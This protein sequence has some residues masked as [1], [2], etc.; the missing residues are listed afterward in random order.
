MTQFIKHNSSVQLFSDNQALK[1]LME[2]KLSKSKAIEED[3]GEGRDSS[4]TV[5]VYKYIYIFIFSFQEEDN[6]IFSAYLLII[7][8]NTMV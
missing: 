5:I 4:L 8:G 1:I 6:S 2:K 7:N 3:T